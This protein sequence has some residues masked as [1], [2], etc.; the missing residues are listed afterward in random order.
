[1]VYLRNLTLLFSLQFQYI[2]AF[3]CQAPHLHTSLTY[4]LR[5]W[6][7]HHLFCIC[8]F[9]RALIWENYVVAVI[10]FYFFCVRENTYFELKRPNWADCWTCLHLICNNNN[11]I[12]TFISNESV[13]FS[14]HLAQAA[15]LK[16]VVCGPPSLATVVVCVCIHG[17]RKHTV[18]IC[19]IGA[20]Y[21][22]ER[23]KPFPSAATA[24]YY[25][26]R[27]FDGYAIRTVSVHLGLLPAYLTYSSDATFLGADTVRHC[28][29]NI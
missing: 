25:S 6:S 3:S 12:I 5:S 22:T 10:C 9:H 21:A 24:L 20:W 7:Y 18:H 4:C 11:L 26:P 19:H 29:V 14:F 13:F 8:I 15:A 23:I 1:M 27:L 2:T 17:Y 16:N 28:E